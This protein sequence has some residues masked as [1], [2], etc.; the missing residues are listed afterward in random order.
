MAPVSSS[1]CVSSSEPDPPEGGLPMSSARR[2]A[3]VSSS[4]CL[5]VWESDW[6]W[7][8]SAMPVPAIAPD[9]TIQQ[10]S[11]KMRNAFAVGGPARLGRFDEIWH[12]ALR[13][14]TL[15]TNAMHKYLMFAKTRIPSAGA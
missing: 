7:A 14:T 9:R 12:S 13:S 2:M 6:A 10:A 15:R 3:P 4:I 5:N 11:A 8:S 1:I